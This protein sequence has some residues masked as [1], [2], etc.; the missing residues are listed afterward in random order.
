MMFF[1]RAAFWLAIVSVFVPRDFAG[2]GFDLQFNT[3]STQIDAGEALGSWCI[4]REALC[5]AGAEA[6]QLGDFLA[7]FAA[8]RIEAA[9]DERNT[10]NS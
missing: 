7:G 6:V 8:N 5:E 9:I 10:A 1:L 3:A 4:D 2:E